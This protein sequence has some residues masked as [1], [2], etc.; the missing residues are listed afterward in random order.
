[1]A[2]LL[3]RSMEVASGSTEKWKEATEI[4][5]CARLEQRRRREKVRKSAESSQATAVRRR[6]NA[7]S[8][9]VPLPEKG[10]RTRSPSL[11]EGEEDALEEGDGLLGG[12]LAEALFPRLGWL[13]FPDGFHLFAAIRFF[14]EL[15]S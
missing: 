7:A 3:D 11:V 6:R 5:T 13:D 4:W 9:V 1:M 2:V 14:H 12:V 15:H 8:S 10:S